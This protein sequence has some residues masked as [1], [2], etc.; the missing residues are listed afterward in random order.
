MR[1]LNEMERLIIITLFVSE[2]RMDWEKVR[3]AVFI[4]LKNL[5]KEEK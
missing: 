4:L 1:E 5:E 2:G 3:W